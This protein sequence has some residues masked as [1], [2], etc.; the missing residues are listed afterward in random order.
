MDN[1]D[2]DFYDWELVPQLYPEEKKTGVSFKGESEEYFSA[3][4]FLHDMLDRKGQSYVVN[5]VL[6]RIVDNPKNKPIK[7]EVKVS[8]GASGKVNV[9]IYNVNKNGQA[10]MLVQKTSQGEISHVKT[11]AFKVCKYILDGT[12]DGVISSQDIEKMRKNEKMGDKK[13]GVSRFCDICEM[14]FKTQEGLKIHKSKEH[15]QNTFKCEVCKFEFNNDEDI[16]RHQ[17]NCGQT[18]KVLSCNKCD[19]TFQN[20]IILENHFEKVHA[21]EKRSK[22][23]Y[24]DEIIVSANQ[25][26]ILKNMRK[27][28]DVCSC[29]EK[30]PESDSV[31]NCEKCDFITKEERNFK[32]H[33][34]D[35]HEVLTRSTSPQLKKRR[36]ES[37]NDLAM[38]ESDFKEVIIIDDDLTK[39]GEVF[40]SDA[41]TE[42]KSY[43]SKKDAK[44]IMSERSKKQDEKIIRKM[45]ENEKKE[46]EYMEK[47]EL[48]INEKE[49]KEKEE[50]NSRMREKKKEKKKKEKLPTIIENEISGSLKPYLRQLPAAAKKVLG[51]G[52][53]LFPVQGDGACGPRTFA[54]WIFQDPTLGPYLARNINAHYVQHWDFWKHKFSFPFTRNIGI[55]KQVTLSTEEELLKFFLN[56]KEGAYLWRGHEDMMAVCNAYQMNIKVITARGHDD[57]N[58]E[59]NEFEPNPEFAGSSD[60]SMGQIPEMTIFH[61]YNVHYSLVVPQESRLATDGGLDYQRE[62]L[63]RKKAEESDKK[64][65][66]ESKEFNIKDIVDKVNAMEEKI[67]DLERNC[68]RLEHENEELSKKI[69]TIE[70]RM[71]VDDVNDEITLG[72]LKNGGLKAQ[73]LQVSVEKTH[74][75][76]EKNMIELHK[77]TICGKEEDSGRLLDD[78]MGIHKRKK[79]SCYKCELNFESKDNLDIHLNMHKK[80]EFSCAKCE[81]KFANE[82]RLEH[83]IRSEHR[84]NENRQFNCEDCFFQGE[85]RIDLRRHIKNTHHTPSDYVEMCYKCGKD[86]TSYYLLMNH[87]NIEH[88]TNR[89]CRY[90]L[91]QECLWGD[92]E[93]WWRHKSKPEIEENAGQDYDCNKC[94]YKTKLKNELSEHE[95]QVH[96]GEKAVC[97]VCHKC[98]YK[99][100]V[101]N[102]YIMHMEEVHEEKKKISHEEK[103]KISEH[104]VSMDEVSDGK[105]LGFQM[106]QKK[107]PPDQMILL[108]EFIKNMALQVRN[109]EKILPNV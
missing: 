58:P 69:D 18:E 82:R 19:Q 104:D 65:K 106:D 52:F 44:E 60:F 1:N 30:I 63:A 92:D 17:N 3:L 11:L 15:G 105:D 37:D 14:S 101:K 84:D 85:A 64:E 22:C 46:K 99:T 66:K 7:V 57:E 61:D 36:K 24:C 13:G 50:K 96:E 59:V 32:R 86:F 81:K 62:E 26:E 29:K 95:K 109:M 102:D 94:D 80:N 54:A 97:Y 103:K 70:A 76:C 83:H 23:E 74:D 9:K 67:R 108:V 68:S 78:H 8:N 40:W 6:L 53:Y 56:S 98:D 25:C 73:N 55:G 91:K 49:R 35:E 75:K 107:N 20:N 39:E 31:H 71:S 43:G 4:K 89:I 38:E 41:R 16:A 90:Y 10:T 87:R 45:M 72:T 77:C 51:D 33:M 21:M 28:Y 48:D 34:R 42:S 93:C 47:R 27:H 88:P 12:I 100:N 79:F 2:E 5:N